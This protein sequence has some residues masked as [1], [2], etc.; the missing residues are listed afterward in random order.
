MIASFPANCL[1]VVN[2]RRC[3]S[4][5]FDLLSLTPQSET[6]QSPAASVLP[7]NPP[8]LSNTHGCRVQSFIRHGNRASAGMRRLP[9]SESCPENISWQGAPARAPSA[10]PRSNQCRRAISREGSNSMSGIPESISEAPYPAPGEMLAAAQAAT[11]FTDFGAGNFREGLAHLLASLERD[12]RMSPGDRAGPRFPACPLIR[13][14][15]QRV[16]SCAASRRRASCS[17][18]S[19]GVTTGVSAG[20]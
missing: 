6:S 13:R 12:A 11:G 1:S 17:R 2:L 14:H 9:I 4:A 15:H 18:R 3:L 20:R 16:R 5:K 8:H 19:S 7:H 10:K